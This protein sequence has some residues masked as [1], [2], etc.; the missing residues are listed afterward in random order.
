METEKDEKKEV[1]NANIAP[2]KVHDLIPEA[3]RTQSNDPNQYPGIRTA[4][5]AQQKG[6]D[7]AAATDAKADDK[8]TD[9][10][11][12]KEK[13]QQ[14]QYATGDATDAAA[15]GNKEPEKVE[16]LSTPHAKTHTT[17]YN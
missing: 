2:E 6:D 3:Y 11:E 14:N 12:K 9:K 15:G 10:S 17:F 4:F 13:K 1:W 8:A 16:V 7:K 5:F